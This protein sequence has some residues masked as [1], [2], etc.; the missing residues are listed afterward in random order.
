M[1]KKYKAAIFCGKEH[2]DIVEKELPDV[3]DDDSVIVKNKIATICGAD[4]NGYTKGD[5][6]AHMLWSGYEFG[7]EMVSEVVEVGKNVTDVKVGDWLFPNLG[8]AHRDHHRMATVGGFSEYIVLPKFSLEGSCQVGSRN[9]PSAFL[10]D[11]SLG[12]KNLC[13]IEPFSVGCKAA[14][15]VHPAGKKCIIIGAGIIG[16]STAV[17]C[18]YF[19]AEKVMVIDFSDFRL[20]NAAHYGILTC[21]PSKEDVDARVYAEFGEAMAYGGKKCRAD[22]FFDCIGIQP[23]IDYFTKYGGFGATLVIVGNHDAKDP[24]F[25]ANTVCFN[26]QYIKGCGMLGLDKCTEYICDMIRKGVDL[27]RLITHTYPLEKIDEAFH[28]HGNVNA[29]HKVAIVYD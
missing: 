22:V 14:E 25:S 12:M 16:L 26:Q 20:E 9:Q 29:A 1:E 18:K 15:S 27:S 17:M 6:D 2:I 24:T 3:L 11:K 23:C 8:Y 19:G 7:H 28:M 13:L 10:L 4:Y 21:N 5:G